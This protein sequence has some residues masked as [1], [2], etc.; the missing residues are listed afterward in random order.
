MLQI[1]MIIII[2][3]TCRA[4]SKARVLLKV[5]VCIT[6]RKGQRELQAENN[7]F[8]CL[9]YKQFLIIPHTHECCGKGTHVISLQFSVKDEKYF[10]RDSYKQST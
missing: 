9:E 6:C 8:L 5:K 4:L 2:I 7:L 1:G 10:V 3:A